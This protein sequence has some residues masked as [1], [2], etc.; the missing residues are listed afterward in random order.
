[1]G[2]YGRALPLLLRRPLRCLLFQICS[3]ATQASPAAGTEQSDR[4]T[5]NG[6]SGAAGRTVHVAAEGLHVRQVLLHGCRTG[7][8]KFRNA[9]TKSLREV[10]IDGVGKTS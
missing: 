3:P 7:G 2:V 10:R 1:V 4:G 8:S 5:G 6:G 9:A